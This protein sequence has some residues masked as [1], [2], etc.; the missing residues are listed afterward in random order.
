MQHLNPV[1]TRDLAEELHIP[2]ATGE[3]T[4]DHA[5]AILSSM[6]GIGTE[7][8]AKVLRRNDPAM[9][10]GA[11]ERLPNGDMRPCWGTKRAIWDHTRGDK[12]DTP[13]L[14]DLIAKWGR[15]LA[16]FAT[17]PADI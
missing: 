2:L 8:A 9:Q 12:K 7:A 15:P 13:A 3:L 5:I 16:F 10:A 11:W 4:R 17:A 14:P 6:G 1:E